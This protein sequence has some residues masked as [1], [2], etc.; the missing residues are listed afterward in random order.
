MDIQY[1][2]LELD[3]QGKLIDGLANDRQGHLIDGLVKATDIKLL[4]EELEQQK[5]ERLDKESEIQSLEAELKQQ[6]QSDIQTLRLDI[7]SLRKELEH[8]K[9][10]GIDK[11]SQIQSLKTRIESL[12]EE[13]KQQKKDEVNKDS[14]SRTQSHYCTA[15]K[16]S[17]IY[18]ILLPKFSSLPFKVACD[19]ETRGGGWTIFLRRMDGSVNFYR[20][21]TE[22]QKGFGDLNGEFFMGLDKLHA[23][24]AERS[25]E[26]LVVLEDFEGENRFEMYDKFAIGGENE[27]YALHTLGNA[28]GTAGD[29]LLRHLGMPFSTFDRDNDK[30]FTNCAEYNTGAWWYNQC[31]DSNLAGKYKEHNHNGVI[32]YHFRGWDH[33]LKRAV[34]MI[35]PIIRP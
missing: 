11:E 18:E 10:D 29:S 21:W 24:T 31:Y 9:K 1:L 35:R 7:Q 23:L 26:L 17:G 33:S 22:Y 20:N 19:A 14:S 8:Q 30:H 28:S 16:S 15:A 3:R 12:K 25:Q 27:L 34:M 2:K 13:L 5:K 32:W 6:S 4:R